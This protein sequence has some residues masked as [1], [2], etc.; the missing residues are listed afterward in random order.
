[1]LRWGPGVICVIC[2]YTRKHV[3][4][5]ITVYWASLGTKNRY[6][7]LLGTGTNIPLASLLCDFFFFFK[8]SS[9]WLGKKGGDCQKLCCLRHFWKGSCIWPALLSHLPC[10]WYCSLRSGVIAKETKWAAPLCVLFY[11]ISI[12]RLFTS[13][14]EE[15]HTTTQPGWAQETFSLEKKLESSLGWLCNRMREGISIY[16]APVVCSPVP[17]ASADHRRILKVN[18]ELEVL[19]KE[20]KGGAGIWA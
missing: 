1:M 14:N 5:V 9:P 20:A 2:L 16:W 11:S 8:K 4:I 17:D 13:L 6:M 18:E 15:L 7:W 3:I 19:D 12:S 10:S